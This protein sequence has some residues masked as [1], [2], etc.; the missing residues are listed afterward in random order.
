M[1]ADLGASPVTHTPG[2]RPW[3]GRYVKL[4]MLIPAVTAAI[5]VAACSSSAPE[6]A[7]T[8][9]PA[10]ST[11]TA[12]PAAKPDSAPAGNGLTGL[13]ATAEYWAAHRDPD[14]HSPALAYGR[15]PALPPHGGRTGDRYT[16]VAYVNG[17]VAAYRVNFRADTG[18]TAALADVLHTEFPPDA[19]WLWKRKVPGQCYQA[20]VKSAKLKAG[21]AGTGLGDGSGE[22]LVELQTVVSGRGMPYFDGS[23]VTYATLDPVSHATAADVGGC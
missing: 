5:T 14:N 7:P 9:T 19:V 17:Y 20:E 8:A 23:D 13:G 6:P 2:H 11:A 12:T 18:T 10:T 22:V 1:I 16:A 21:L 4:R 3:H 15:D